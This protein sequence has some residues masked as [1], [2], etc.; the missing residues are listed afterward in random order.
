MAASMW[1]VTGQV[2][3]APGDAA[4]IAA[5]H[6]VTPDQVADLLAL[7]LDN[8]SVDWSAVEA[9]PALTPPGP[10]AAQWLAELGERL[11]GVVEVVSYD[12]F[13][14]LGLDAF[15]D[16]FDAF[17]DPV[18]VPAPI[19]ADGQALVD[20]TFGAGAGVLDADSDTDLPGP[21][22]DPDP[23]EPDQLDAFD[24]VGEGADLPVAQPHGDAAD[25][26]DPDGGGFELDQ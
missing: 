21:A 11:R 7:Y 4:A 25:L 3:A 16:G 10:D 26:D 8:A 20:A 23:D 6:G 18:P 22:S 1:E 24:L 12:G 15:D 5:A 13:A 19:A 14:A 17:G 9:V 2:L